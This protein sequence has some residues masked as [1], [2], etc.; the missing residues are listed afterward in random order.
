MNIRAAQFVNS[1]RGDISPSEKCV[2]FVMAI[3]ADF[4][5]AVAYMS[6]TTLAAEAGYK[7][8]QRVSPIVQKLVSYGIIRVIGT[9]S[10]GRGTTKYQFTFTVNR[11]SGVT[12]NTATDGESNRTP[13]SAVEDESNRTLGSAVEKTALSGESNCTQNGV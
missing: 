6:M 5:N 8:R 7:H 13:Q 11:D 10:K 12:V 1:L 4:K 9:K 2:A 3:H